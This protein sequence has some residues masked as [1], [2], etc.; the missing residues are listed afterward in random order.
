ML[1]RELMSM[2]EVILSLQ[3]RQPLARWTA[4][5]RMPSLAN[6]RGHWRAHATLRATQRGLAKELTEQCCIAR[7]NALER[8]LVVAMVRISPKFLDS[9]NVTGATKCVRDGIA[10]ALGIDDR[11]PRV[12]WLPTQQEKGAK[13][14]CRAEF[15]LTKGEP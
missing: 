2:A 9:D 7:Y 6:S 5:M 11:D 14:G 8:G 1:G 15:Y 12:L 10:E 3:G 4:E 13:Q